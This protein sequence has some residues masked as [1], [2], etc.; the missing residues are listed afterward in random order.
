VT[1]GGGNPAPVHRPGPDSDHLAAMT[2]IEHLRELRTRLIWIVGSIIVGMGLSLAVSQSVMNDLMRLCAV[3]RFQFIEPLEALTT[4]L[5]VALILGFILASPMAL[6]QLVAFI[7]PAL[8]PSE[9][10]VLFVALP[11]VGGLFAAGLAFGRY[12]VLARTIDFLAGF[13]SE[14]GSASGVGL[15]EPAWRVG[16]YIGFVTNLLFV[17]GLAFQTPLVVFLLAKLRIVS[18]ELL[19][20][21]RRHAILLLAVLAAVMTPTPDPFTMLMVLAP[22]VLL[23]ELGIVLARFA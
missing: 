1:A 16:L 2:L 17:I 12:V 8:H 20:R 11:A 9:R 14:G 7:L 10:R 5:R 6:Y 23:Y 13:L 4:Y 21:Y 3:C 15:A 18:P 19:R 22:M